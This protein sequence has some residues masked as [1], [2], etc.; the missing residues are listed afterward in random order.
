M[1]FDKLF[2]VVF[3]QHVPELAEGDVGRYTGA[4][5]THVGPVAVVAPDASGYDARALGHRP[6]EPGVGERVAVMS[7]VHHVVSVAAAVSTGPVLERVHP[8]P[9]RPKVV[10]LVV[11]HATP[12]AFLFRVHV[13]CGACGG[14]IYCADGRVLGR[15]NPECSRR[16]APQ[17]L[18]RARRDR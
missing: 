7:P 8:A 9:Q 13:C 10:Q 17:R 4:R 18:G 12:G 14:L 1:F 16:R 3:A 11:A 5:P 2:A 15:T 6:S